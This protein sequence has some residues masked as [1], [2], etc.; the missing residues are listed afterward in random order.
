MSNCVRKPVYIGK[1]GQ[2][3]MAEYVTWVGNIEMSSDS[4]RNLQSE[5]KRRGIC[6]AVIQR[7]SG[8]WVS[9][10]QDLVIMREYCPRY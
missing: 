1:P 8:Y 4:L 7:Q 6:L 5:I 9:A 10:N 3:P 2:T